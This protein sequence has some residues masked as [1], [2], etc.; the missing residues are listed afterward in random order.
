MEIDQSAI[1]HNLKY[2]QSKI[3]KGVRTLVV[4]KAFSYGS[5]AEVIAK[6]LENH[7]IDYLA[8]SY[9]PEGVNLRKAGIELPILV[10]H[11]QM[12]NFED[13]I[14]YNLEPA[15]YSFRVLEGF[16]EVLKARNK[17]QY[18]VHIKFNSGMNRLGFRTNE[19]ELLKG[20]LEQFQDQIRTVTFFSHLAASEDETQREFSLKQI[21]E[22]EEFSDQLKG[23]SLIYSLRHICNSSGI[24]KFP[25]A[26]FEMVRLGIG[27]YGFGNISK[28]T[29]QLKLAVR[30]KTKISQIQTIK[31]LES[32][33]YGRKFIS[34]SERK[35][36]VLPL[37]YADGFKRIWSNGNAYVKINGQK[38][39]FAGQICM[40][41][42]M[43]DVTDIDCAEGDEVIIFDCQEDVI[44]LAESA[45][46]IT[47]EILTSISQRGRRK[48][49]V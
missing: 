49:K 41:I 12:E 5:D 19:V 28:E 32:V 20:K 29:E 15:L 2:F 24:L 40:C 42:S 46:T 37:G 3:D 26:H 6:L 36:A 11:P 23:N 34:D 17:N 45:Q 14:Q 10:F 44:Q 13:I 4:I 1:V 18:P 8:V 25:E 22:F 39:P 21:K 47:Y 33:G 38:A 9:A 7:A 16:Y 48:I 27:L 35:I 43:V 31:P 30:L